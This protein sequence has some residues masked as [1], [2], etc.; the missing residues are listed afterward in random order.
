MQFRGGK[1]ELTQSSGAAGRRA[2]EGSS[3]SDTFRI[4][5]L[6]KRPGSLN[7]PYA[8]DAGEGGGTRGNCMGQGEETEG[9]PLGGT[10]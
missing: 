7:S 1:G 10:A 5:N 6:P 3:R 4:S 9:K 8:E 2:V